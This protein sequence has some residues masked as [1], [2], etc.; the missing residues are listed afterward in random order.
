MVNAQPKEP[1]T[2]G[3]YFN[4]LYNN[5][6]VKQKCVFCPLIASDLSKAPG[7]SIL[8]RQNIN[9]IIYEK[10]LSASGL[11]NENTK[12]QEGQIIS[13]SNFITVTGINYAEKGGFSM[14]AIENYSY[15]NLKTGRIVWS[16][17]ASGYTPIVSEPY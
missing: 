12:L 16:K 15:T 3:I 6:E 2:V 10:T 4:R 7:V 14:D 8:E 5:P 9:K 17:N 1:N 11:V 13:P